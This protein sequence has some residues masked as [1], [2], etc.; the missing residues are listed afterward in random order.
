VDAFDILTWS[1]HL[2]Y[3][4]DMG[5]Y[6]F[7]RIEDM[8]DFFRGRRINPQY[9]GEKVI[10]SGTEGVMRYDARTAATA[11]KDWVRE[12]PSVLKRAVYSDVLPAV[13]EGEDYLRRLCYDYEYDGHLVFQDFYEAN[14]HA[15][16]YHFI[17]ACRAIVWG[18]S[19]FEEQCDGTC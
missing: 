8:F 18:I 1:G 9:W 19:K 3:T 14:L 4:G 6:V 2:C 17:F 13:E 7:A 10:A 15:Y 12:Y 16:T 11:I 5:T